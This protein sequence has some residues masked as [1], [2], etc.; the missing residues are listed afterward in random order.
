MR[1]A[2]LQIAAAVLLAAAPLA[3]A[4]TPVNIPLANGDFS[5]PITAAETGYTI[6]PCTYGADAQSC[7]YATDTVFVNTNPNLDHN[8]WASFTGAPDANMLIVNAATSANVAVYQD[9]GIAVA[10][11]HAYQFAGYAAS[12]Y[13]Q[14]PAVLETDFNGVNAGTSFTVSKVGAFE[15]FT[16]DWFSGSATTLDL[17]LIDANLQASG[18]DFALDDLTLTEVPEPASAAALIVGLTVITVIR[19]RRRKG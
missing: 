12:N 3:H 17:A 2:T 9:L 10:A 6:A 8:L 16:F 7:Q 18:N 14:S 19:L 15:K 11:N 4:G 1:I 13:F 5:S